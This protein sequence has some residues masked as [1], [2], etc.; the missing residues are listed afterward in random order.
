MSDAFKESNTNT[1]RNVVTFQSGFG[2][3]ADEPF[4]IGSP[5]TVNSNLISYNEFRPIGG[6][7]GYVA[8]TGLNKH[9]FVN[10][11]SGQNHFI[12][13]INGNIGQSSNGIIS[14]DFLSMALENGTTTVDWGEMQLIN[15]DVAL[16][17]AVYT[18]LDAGVSTTLNWDK[19]LL[20]G[21]NWASTVGFILSGTAPATMTSAGVKGQIATSGTNLYV[22]TGTSQWGKVPLIA[23]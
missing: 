19:R 14:I 17:W 12:D 9:A 2:V 23:F 20:L 7:S 11:A 1:Y 10:V 16:S 13:L 15:G 3:I 8:Y 18:L 4:F 6:I 22:C 5:T 21:G